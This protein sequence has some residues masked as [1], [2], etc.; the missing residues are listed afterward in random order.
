MREDPDIIMLGEMRDSET[1]EVAMTAAETG[2][3]VFSTVHMVGVKD[4][5]DRIISAFPHNYQDNIRSQLASVLRG[6]ISQALLPHR[7]GRGRVAA[8]E[9]MPGTPA[10]ANLIR[11]DHTHQIP[12]FLQTQR[13]DGMCTL[14]QSLSERYAEELISRDVAL[15]R[16]QDPR[17][18]ENLLRSVDEKKPRRTG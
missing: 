17:E 11:E 13:K 9:I 6:V 2:H 5:V 8:F 3:L 18:L 16:A 7:S 14:D 10:I 4:T 1:M 12:S 15:E